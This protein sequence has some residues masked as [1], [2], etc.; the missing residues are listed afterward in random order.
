MSGRLESSGIIGR[1][2]VV[3]DGHIDLF[4]RGHR[5]DHVVDILG[6]S[7]LKCGE[8]QMVEQLPG[9]GMSPAN[10]WV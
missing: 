9:G 2:H 8:G 1:T 6:A 7:D 4:A 5:V 10:H 3:G